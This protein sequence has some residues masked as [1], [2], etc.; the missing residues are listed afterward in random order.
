[1]ILLSGHSLTPARGVPAESIGL[2]MKERDGSVSITPTDMSGISIGTWMQDE[3]EPGKGIVYRVKSIR[4]VYGTKTTTVELEHAINLLRDLVL[5]GEV[6]AGTMAG[7]GGTTCT[8]KQAVQYIL[9][10]QSDWVLGRFD[11]NVSNPYK[12]DGDTLL[13]ALET[14]SSTLDNAWWSYDF[15]TY[16]FKLNITR[17]ADGVESEL[18]CGRNLTTLTKSI[19]KS[20]MY[21]R[22]Y[23]IGKDDLHLS[24]GGYVEKNTNLYGVVSKVEVDQTLE[25]EAELRAWANERLSK[26]AEPLVTITAE[27]MELADSTGE[28]LDRLT[29]GRI[30][31]IPLPEFG[32][33]I[34]ERITE[35]DVPDKLNQPEIRKLTLA[36]SHEDI[37]R[38]IAENMKRGGRGGRASGR[39]SKEDHAWIEDTNDHVALV[40]EGIVGKD[41]QGNPNW[42]RLSKIVVD[43]EGIHQTVQS[44]QNKQ[45]IAEAAIDVTE[46]QISQFVRAVGKDGEITSASIVLAINKDNS[47]EARIAADHV[48]ISGNTTLSGVLT[49]DSSG[50]LH[51]KRTGVFEGNLTLITSGSYIQAPNV[52]IASGGHLRLGGSGTGEYYDLTASNIQGFIKSAEVSGNV[53]TL[54]PV[55][56][57]AITF[58]KATSVTGSWSGRYFTAIA[59]QNGIEVGRKSGIVYDGIV[60]TGDISVSGKNV[61]RDFIVYSDDGSGDAD[62]QIMRKT[63]T[64]NASD[65]YDDGKNSVTVSSVSRAVQTSDPGNDYTQLTQATISA[66]RWLKLD[67]AL[68][69]GR[70]A[71]KYKM[72]LIHG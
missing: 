48:R 37:T 7:N 30:C 49:V 71:G 66:D 26:H 33:N 14:V 52:N 5:F 58:S 42:I 47:S 17:K 50:Y 45:V 40:A 1:M 4:Q 72:K 54:T 2:K 55:H 21:T 34:E 41:A 24:G 39:Q 31:R 10:Q 32:E 67:I 18:R 60:P 62:V 22:F 29:L 15:T 23:P 6:K 57:D 28:P 27:G 9:R 46:K 13:D 8:A 70:N 63:L 43:G 35:I 16:P 56:G 38:I 36:N 25:T 44:I 65:V 53:L 3:D 68:S 61:M 69:S 64:I 11:Y 59:R 20:S 19:D 12:F 51:V